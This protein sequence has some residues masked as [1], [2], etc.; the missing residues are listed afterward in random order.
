MPP[1][2]SALAEALDIDQKTLAELFRYDSDPVSLDAPIGEDGATTLGDLVP[3]S[4][5]GSPIELVAQAMLASHV[6]VILGL[7]PEAERRV[8]TLRYGIDRGEPR[9]QAA[10][11][12]ILNLPA[13]RVRRIEHDALV[14][15]RRTL[16]GSEAWEL[17]AS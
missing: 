7:L 4:S 14:K 12:G 10:V 9:T 5:S 8:L 2:F 16:A 13:D 6:D 1:T 15:L 17:L 3:S 11:G